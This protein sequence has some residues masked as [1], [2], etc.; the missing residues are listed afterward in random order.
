VINDIRRQAEEAKAASARE[1]AE[2]QQ[3]NASA[4]LAADA[5]LQQLTRDYEAKLA[6]HRGAEVAAL[7]S[8]LERSNMELVKVKAALSKEATELRRAEDRHAVLLRAVQLDHAAAIER[9]ENDRAIDLKNREAAL[10]Q[11]HAAETAQLADHHRNMLEQTQQ[12]NGLKV[13]ELSMQ[14]VTLTAKLRQA[15]DSLKHLHHQ[16]AALD[17]TENNNN[18]SAVAA[19]Q[20]LLHERLRLSSWFHRWRREVTNRQFLADY[21]ALEANEAHARTQLSLLVTKLAQR[22]QAA[23]TAL[24]TARAAPSGAQAL[25][26]HSA[27]NSRPDGT[28]SSGDAGGSGD[29]HARLLLMSQEAQDFYQQ[30]PNRN[31]ITGDACDSMTP[32]S[33]VRDTVSPAD[34]L[35]DAG[36]PPEAVPSRDQTHGDDG[37]IQ[38]TYDV[39]ADHHRFHE[40]SLSTKLF[41]SSAAVTV[42]KAMDHHRSPKRPSPRQAANTGSGGSPVPGQLRSPGPLHVTDVNTSSSLS[43]TPPRSGS[44]QLLQAAAADHFAA[45][46]PLGSSTQSSHDDVDQLVLRGQQ[47][48]SRMSA[49]MAAQPFGHGVGSQQRIRPSRTGPIHIV[50]RSVEAAASTG[51]HPAVARKRLPRQDF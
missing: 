50:M 41:A 44:K 14:L 7:Q 17:T 8:E 49:A 5:Q 37:R 27:E 51:M 9:L 21:E 34:E 31:T 35:A 26:Q 36:G 29:D 42:H 12:D 2:L 32:F 3:Q 4:V 1:S 13:A 46:I 47:L 28:A 48:L 18:R 22:Q 23:L 11:Q 45:P 20:V 24:S 38:A 25:Y 39:S 16:R 40:S 19:A 10:R 15:E 6:T 33:I 30:Q 43:S